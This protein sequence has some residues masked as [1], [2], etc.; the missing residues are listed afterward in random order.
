MRKLH[1]MIVDDEQNCIET[2]KL[3]LQE[4]NDDVEVIATASNVT[5][6]LLAI[7]S[8]P[9][10]L[11]ILFLDV[12]MPGGDGF[13]L[14]QELTTIEFKV[15]FTTAYS[16]FAIKAIKFSAMDYLLKPIDNEELN[17]AIK[18]YR[19][20]NKPTDSLM[21]EEVKKLFNQNSK[22]MDKV[23][24][25]TL[26]DVQFIPID[27]IYYLKSDS[28]YTTFF[29]TSPKALVSSKNIGY[30]EDLLEHQN[31]FRIHNSLLVNLNKVNKFHRGK[32]GYLELDNGTTLEVSVRR[33]DDLL[34]KIKLL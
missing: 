19:L 6:A 26:S 2:L 28:N 24:V 30:Y 5:E 33:K 16:H 20:L 25:T 8:L 34:K 22:P 1:V 9:Q 4:Y 27:Q 13:S 29:T 21:L 7:N 18:N 23:A 17:T 14:L 32:P 12:Q 3:L 15:I 11:D 31:F 10:K